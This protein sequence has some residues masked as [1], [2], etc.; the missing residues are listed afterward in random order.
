MPLKIEVGFHQKLGQPNYSSVGSSCNVEF[1]ADSCLHTQDLETFH[2]QVRHAFAACQSVVEEELAPYRATRPPVDGGN[3][4]D[5]NTPATTAV[6]RLSRA[7][8]NGSAGLGVTERQLH[9]LEKLAG[10]IPGVGMERLAPIAETLFGKSLD[11][12]DAGSASEMIDLLKGI[13]SGKT[14]PSELVSGV[15]L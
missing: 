14:D 11:Q 6:P 8:G 3:A 1:Q 7:S 5:Q 4:A 13:C 9:Y 15:A 12:L 2:S 10:Q